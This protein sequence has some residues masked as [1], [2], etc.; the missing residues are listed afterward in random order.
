MLRVNKIVISQQLWAK[1]GL[2]MLITLSGV[3]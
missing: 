2:K 1:K 3:N